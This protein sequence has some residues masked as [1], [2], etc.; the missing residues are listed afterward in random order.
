VRQQVITA[1]GRLENPQAG[2]QLQRLLRSGA[3]FA[4]RMLVLEAAR[5]NLRRRCP[6]TASGRGWCSSVR[7]ARPAAK[8]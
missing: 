7:G 1:L 6:C 2:G 5:E 8:Q 4:A 3:R